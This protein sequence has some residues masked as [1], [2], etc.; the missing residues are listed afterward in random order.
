MDICIRLGV[1]FGTPSGQKPGNEKD[2][3]LRA[4]SLA[5]AYSI[6]MR[7]T[8]QHLAQSRFSPSEWRRGHSPPHSE[9][10]PVGPP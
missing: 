9:S 10:S 4:P 2:G 5:D 8:K 7:L 1:P 3:L 6:T